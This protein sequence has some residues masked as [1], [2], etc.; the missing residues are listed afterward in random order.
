[1]SDDIDHAEQPGKFL[2]VMLRKGSVAEHAYHTCAKK[3]ALTRGKA[4]SAAATGQN[5][6]VRHGG[7]IIPRPSISRE[8]DDRLLAAGIV[9]SEIH[10]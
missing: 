9:P 4:R 3:H 8:R 10:E 1:M 2:D 6:L 5:D 7:R